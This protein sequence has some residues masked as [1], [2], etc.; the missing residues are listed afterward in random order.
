MKEKKKEQKLEIDLKAYELAKTIEEFS[1]SYIE[2]MRLIERIKSNF[3]WARERTEVKLP[4]YPI[5]KWG[6]KV[7]VPETEVPGIGE[8]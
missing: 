8:N 6:Q 1:G 7:N 5:D 3:E 4:N 2:S